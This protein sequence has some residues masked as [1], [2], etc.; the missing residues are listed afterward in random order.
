MGAHGHV[1]RRPRFAAVPGAPDPTARLRLLQL[2][3]PVLPVGAFAYSQGLEHA[4]AAGTVHDEATA[5]QWIADALTFSVA[6]WEL[7][8]VLHMLH[9]WRGEAHDALALLDAL[10]VASRETAELRAETLQMGH[11]LVRLLADVDALGGASHAARLTAWPCVS[12]PAAWTAVAATL[13]IDDVAVLEAYGWS[14]LENQVLAALKAVPLGQSAGQR[15]L[16]AL[17][18]VLAGIIPD[19]LQTP[20][21]AL[22]NWTPG[23]ALASAGHETQYSRLFRS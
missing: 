19:V 12:Y 21:G 18:A 2:A 1:R 10:F 6:R 11:S 8:A 13:A 16:A 20:A 9:A 14:W 4:I 22:A 3:S 23:L 15:L 5:R 7:P 17:T